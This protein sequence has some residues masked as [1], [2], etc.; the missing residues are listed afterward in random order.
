M[1]VSKGYH[2]GIQHFQLSSDR[3]ALGVKVELLGTSGNWTQNYFNLLPNSPVVVS[4][5]IGAEAGCEALV[6]KSYV[7]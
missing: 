7:P 4:V 3:L 1:C 6:F 5:P 2:N